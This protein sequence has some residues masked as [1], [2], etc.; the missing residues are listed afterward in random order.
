MGDGVGRDA[1]FGDG[2]PGGPYRQRPG[3]GSVAIHPLGGRGARVV[4]TRRRKKKV[5]GKRGVAR[6]IEQDRAAGADFVCR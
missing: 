5:L 1:R 4:A 6:A 3:L 2:R